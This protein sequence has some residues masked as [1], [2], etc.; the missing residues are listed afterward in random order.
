M[1]WKKIPSLSALR[2]FEAAARH[3][4]FTKAANEL[5][6]TQAAVAQHVRALE[7]ELNTILVLRKGRGI[8]I[9]EGGLDFARELT[10]S[11]RRI[12]DSIENF[13]VASNNRPIS[14]ATTP[15]FAS[16]WLM[17]RMGLFW[18]EHPNI[19]VSIA[20]SVEAVDLR[21]DGYDLAIRYGDGDWP[22][23]DVELLTDGQFWVVAHPDLLSGRAGTCL[24][25]VSDFPWFFEENMLERQRLIEQEG[26]D[27]DDVSIKLLLTNTLVLSAVRA[28]L[29]VGIQ[30]KSL[31]ESDV[32]RGALSKICAL[33]H[34]DFGYYLL[35]LPDRIR[36]GLKEFKRWLKSQ[37][38]H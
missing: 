22:G 10:N 30:S 38:N 19:Q 20:P 34:P 24:S 27:F 36:P 17:P 14:V 13:E 21:H 8:E 33:K 35:S 4:S 18:S 5:N 32:E 6:V 16:N 23:L 11:F 26:V 25:D 9:T 12:A 2:A 15:G 31:I 37:S 3:K 7:R 29:G 28:G 1:D